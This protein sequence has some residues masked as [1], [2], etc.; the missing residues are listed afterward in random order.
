MKEAVGI[1]LLGGLG[2]LMRYSINALFIR[3]ST[4]LATLTVN[5]L[6]CFILGLV[7]TYLNQIKLF[8]ISMTTIL[9]VGFLG[10]LTTFSTLMG[11]S[12]QLLRDGSI[13]LA[14]GNVLLQVLMG[15]VMLFLGMR[16]GSAL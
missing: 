11:E 8:N 12:L 5:M 7:V 14:I 10:S 1:F 16:L 2:A 4:L 15:L 13:L 9:A 6:G 3:Q